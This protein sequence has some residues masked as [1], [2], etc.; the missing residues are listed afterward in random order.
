MEP[1]RTSLVELAG[2]FFRL[3]LISFGGPAAHTAMME[4]EFVTRRGWLTRAHFLD[5][6]GATNLIPGPNST[7]MTMHIGYERAGW[8]GLFV[9][10]AAFIFPAAL[11]T[12]FLA[13][14]YVTYGALPEVEPF[15]Y[16]I[17]PAVI[18]I[19]LAAVWKLGGKAMKDWRFGVLG[20]AVMAAVLLGL[21]EL[22]A[23]FAGGILGMFWFRAPASSRPVGMV[24]LIGQD[25]TAV[26]AAGAAA[27][28]IAGVSLWNLGLYFLKIGAILY[29]SGYVLI[30]FLEGGLVDELGWIS[31]AQ[32]LDAV[33]IGQFTP[34]PVLTTATFLGYVI[35]GAP[36]AVV[37]TTAIFLPSFFFVLI[38][39]P[40]I[41][42]LRRSA[43][44]AAFLD[45][46]NMA[47]I[48]LMAAVV[49]QLGIETLTGWRPI[50]IALA[51]AGLVLRFKVNAA[52]I[53]MGSAVAGWLLD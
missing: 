24:A 8:P 19:I 39:N 5:L 18:S 45:A 47:A 9:A 1:A 46:V 15:L 43:W 11:L 37:A 4:D 28:A 35:A 49:I 48:A 16:G 40:L 50:L 2:H 13:W 42:K 25:S 34:G 12:G 38:L 29:G 21:N 6:V 51:A 52:W 22:Q 44:T 53:V 27:G 14:L 10:G 17:K 7:E 32:L 20:A 41:P 33:A 30:A 36:G 26:V 31:R 3:G 23:L